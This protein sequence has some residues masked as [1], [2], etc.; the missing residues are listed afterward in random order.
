[1]AGDHDDGGVRELVPAHAHE[2]EAVHISNSEVHD[3]QFGL[4]GA[5]G[6]DTIDAGGAAK[7]LVTSGFAELGHELEDC[8]FVV[9]DY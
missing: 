2:V 3:H 7:D 4:V 5:D 8:G 1:M 9:Y 6:G